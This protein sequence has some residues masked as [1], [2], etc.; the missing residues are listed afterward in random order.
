MVGDCVGAFDAGVGLVVWIRF[1]F[2][3]TFVFWVSGMGTCLL[4]L[5]NFCLFIVMTDRLFLLVFACLVSMIWTIV[6]CVCCLFA[7]KLV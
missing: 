2:G 1:V 5:C 3:L 7:V 4:G 6:G